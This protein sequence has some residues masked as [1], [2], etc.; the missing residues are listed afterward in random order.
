MLEVLRYLPHRLKS[1]PPHMRPNVGR[2]VLTFSTPCA[3]PAH[4]LV[5]DYVNNRYLKE[6]S[7]NVVWFTWTNLWMSRLLCVWMLHCPLLA[8]SLLPRFFMNIPPNI[9]AWTPW[10][11]WWQV[12]VCCTLR[13]SLSLYFDSTGLVPWIFSSNV[14]VARHSND[15]QQCIPALNSSDQP[16]HNSRYSKRKDVTLQNPTTLT[17]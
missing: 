8:N 3:N 1:I 4:S 15:Q 9:P 13:T 16:P 6:I 11:S 7:A 10:K 14:A 12:L 17:S 2:F 5:C